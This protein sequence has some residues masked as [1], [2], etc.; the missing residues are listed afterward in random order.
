[1]SKCCFNPYEGLNLSSV[2][3]RQIRARQVFSEE[4]Y[5]DCSETFEFW[6][7]KNAVATQIE[8]CVETI[9]K[10]F[11][12]NTE[13]K[14]LKRIHSGCILIGPKSE[15][16]QEKVDKLI[17]ALGDRNVCHENMTI[18]LIHVPRYPALTKTQYETSNAIWPVRVITPLVDIGEDLDEIKK[19]KILNRLISLGSTSRGACILES[20]DCAI[21][22]VGYAED[23]N[24]HFH[25]KHAVLH[26]AQQLGPKSDYLATDYSVYLLGEPCVMCAMG[27]L[28]SRVKEVYFLYK[29]GE[30]LNFH[31][32]GST[33]SVHCQSQLN[34]RFKVFQIF[35]ED[36]V[37]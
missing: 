31:G 3:A 10:H 6:C 33:L 19:E 1:M 15:G 8:S 30:K 16:S 28:H 11:P 21:S 34:H 12:L 25:F 2:K 24:S 23:E 29:S 13:F 37:K 35:I 7:I 26:A 36:I 14:F 27:L 20:P 9:G 22:V 18:E 17:V 32:F 4:Y 5:R